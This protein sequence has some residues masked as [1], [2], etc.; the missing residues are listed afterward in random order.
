MD[1]NF[2][3]DHATTIQLIFFA[4]II[5]SLWHAELLFNTE[6]LKSKWTHTRVNLGFIVTAVLIQLP[7]TIILIKVMG[8]TQNHHWGLLYLFPFSMNFLEKLVFG[9]LML[10]FFE[11]LYHVMM[12][13]A[14]YL[15]HFHLIHHSDMKLDVSTTVREHP[16]ETFFRVISMIFVMY[17]TG[18]TLPILI[19]RQFIQ[20]LFN[21]S[22]H[23][24]F[25]LPGKLERV[26]SFVFITPG[27]H[28]V[29]HHHKLPYTDSNYGDILCIW[30]RIFGTYATLDQ[31]KIVYGLDVTNHLKICRFN[32]LLNYPFQL[33]RTR[34]PVMPEQDAH[35]LGCLKVDVKLIKI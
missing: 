16:A 22:S 34:K 1:F 3:T 28:K 26:L 27:L 32:A 35:L 9:I 4:T 13:R 17:L 24:A 33:K 31:S 5:I 29:H 25:S 23:S 12:H 21:I 14:K 30:D 19:I 7:L 20:S 2:N 8:W 11:Y 15:W 18:V 6:N 10:D